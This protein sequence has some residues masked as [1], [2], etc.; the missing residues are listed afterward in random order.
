MEQK[1]INA[2]EN[3]IEVQKELIGLLK[4][5]ISDLKASQTN[6]NAPQSVPSPWMPSTPFTAPIFPPSTFPEPFKPYIYCG[7]PISPNST[8]AVTNIGCS[9]ADLKNTSGY[10]SPETFKYHE[11]HF[12]NKGSS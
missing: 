4:A 12:G 8:T 5:E 10:I 2:L 11:I 7:D 1:L 6:T 3:T 9:G